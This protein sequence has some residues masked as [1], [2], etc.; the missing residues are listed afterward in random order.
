[1][2]PSTGRIDKPMHDAENF[3]TMYDHEHFSTGLHRLP[4]NWKY[5]FTLVLVTALVSGCSSS[6]IGLLKS[7]DN[8][9]ASTAQSTLIK[10]KLG[11]DNPGAFDKDKTQ[12]KTIS[13]E[14]KMETTPQKASTEIP[15]KIEKKSEISDDKKS[16]PT[17][18]GPDLPQESLKPPKRL[19]GTEQGDF[20]EL[21]DQKRGD[22]PLPPL[23]SKPETDDKDTDGLEEEER[24]PEFRKHDHSKYVTKIKNSAIDV[25][26]REIDSVHV[27]MC[28]NSTTDEWSLGVYFV[29]GKNYYFRTYVWDPIENIWAEAFESE[30]RPYAGLKKH[31]SF[32]SAGKKCVVLKGSEAQ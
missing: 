22:K 13:P 11:D 23:R 15:E 28:R 21:K 10:P 6:F 8:P 2:G 32:S 25:V 1:M 27:R 16:M 3:I 30:K 26:N 17:Q 14:A 18:S 31:L 4:L 9:G 12:G 20:P 29:Q 19:T 24:N 7:K 5:V